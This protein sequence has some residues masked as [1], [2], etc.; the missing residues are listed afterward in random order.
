MSGG[1]FHRKIPLAVADHHRTVVPAAA[2]VGG[3]VGEE[4]VHQWCH[5]LRLGTCHLCHGH[6]LCWRLHSGFCSHPVSW[7]CCFSTSYKW[8]EWGEEGSWNLKDFFFN[9]EFWGRGG[10]GRQVWV[11]LA[12]DGLFDVP[13]T[14]R[15]YLRVESAETILRGLDQN[16]ISQ[17]CY[18]VEIYHSAPEP[19]ISCAALIE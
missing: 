4:Q 9:T 2:A 16:G 18:I 1:L 15:V 19:S 10:R 3:A 14:C 12:I 5:L 17:A 11:C 7:H 13:P 8:W 6:Q